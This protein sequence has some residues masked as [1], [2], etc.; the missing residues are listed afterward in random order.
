MLSV[1]PK[2][3]HFCIRFGTA[4]DAIWILQC[5]TE[6]LLAENLKIAKENGVIAE[7]Y[8][9]MI[10]KKRDNKGKVKK[11]EKGAKVK[12]MNDGIQLRIQNK[13]SRQK[14]YFFEFIDA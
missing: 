8:I 6:H 7:R 5:E 2:H 10:K 4:W 11:E 1:T 12:G 9:H 13:K 3:L 14:A